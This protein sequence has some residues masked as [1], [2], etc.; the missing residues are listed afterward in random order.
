MNRIAMFAIIGLPLAMAA[1]AQTGAYSNTAE[2]CKSAL[3]RVVRPNDTVFIRNTAL[4][5]ATVNGQA[6]DTVTLDIELNDKPVSMRCA[7]PHAGSLN[8]GTPGAVEIVYA[9]Q[10]LSADQVAALNQA[11]ADNEKPFAAFR[12]RLPSFPGINIYQTEGKLGRPAF[13]SGQDNRQDDQV[14]Q[15]N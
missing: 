15:K 9:G 8:A 1:C 12:K 14:P 7:Y 11:V 4:G 2:H 3:G 10:T 5:Q 13:P 6:V